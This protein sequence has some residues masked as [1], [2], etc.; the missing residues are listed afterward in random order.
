MPESAFPAIICGDSECIESP[1][2]TRFL[3][4]RYCHSKLTVQSH[5]CDVTA[6]LSSRYSHSTVAVLSLFRGV[7]S[8]A[9]RFYLRLCS[10]VTVLALYW[11]TTAAVLSR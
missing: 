11:L 2:E 6:T 9:R 8:G 1:I 7:R 4:T 10:T 5:Y 3:H